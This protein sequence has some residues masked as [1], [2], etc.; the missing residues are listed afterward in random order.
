MPAAFQE[1]RQVSFLQGNLLASLPVLPEPQLPTDVPALARAVCEAIAR[2]YE[3]A[4]AERYGITPGQF[5]Q[6]VGAVIV[7]YAGQATE[8]E[9]LELAATLRVAELTLTRACSAGNEI[10]W[11]LFL[12]R[13]RGP[14]YESAYRIARNEDT[15]RELADELYADLYGVPKHDGRRVSK[16]D[17]YMGRGSLEG[18]L[19]TVLSQ[20]YVDRYR[21]QAREVSLDEQLEAGVSFAEPPAASAPQPDDRVAAAVSKTLAELS[22]EE[23]FLLASYY[24]DERTL[25]E[26]ALQ[27]RVHESTISR[28]LDRMVRDLRK[29]IRKRL[30]ASGLNSRN[31]DEMLEDLDV[32]D[33]NVD[34]TA[35]LRQ[36]TS[37]GA[38][39]KRMDR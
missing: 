10:A 8:E 27:L 4:G 24:L 13:Y 34:V 7:R 38:F 17:Y 22:Y 29:R 20:K 12:T 5:L 25:A 19:R 37:A 28:R 36:E 15:G 2:R 3:E 23:R 31:C 1:R 11:D 33:L 30:L 35:N 21:S 26:I 16:L 18:W 6:I 14:L 9:Q 32:R 39:Y